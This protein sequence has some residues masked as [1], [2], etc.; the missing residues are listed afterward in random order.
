MMTLPEELVLLAVQTQQLRS[1]SFSLRYGI[2]G[3]VLTELI[4]RNRLAF[5]D[6]RLI[7]VDATPTGGF[8]ERAL[9]RG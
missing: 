8:A 1:R 6:A 3:A 4:L 5:S 9:P 7:A 2:V